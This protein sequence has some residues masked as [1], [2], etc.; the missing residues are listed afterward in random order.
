V[1]SE[2]VTRYELFLPKSA[3]P[4]VTFTLNQVLGFSF[5]VN[6][7]DGAGRVGWMEWTT[8]IGMTKTP[9]Y[10][11][12]IALVEEIPEPDGG[13]G[14]QGGTGAA[15]GGSGTG[16]AGAS[17]GTPAAAAD[18]SDGCGCR[19]HRGAAMGAAWLWLA[20]LWL[21]MRRRCR[22]QSRP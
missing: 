5:L 3:L 7:A 9:Y 8:G 19:T 10:F 12:E 13:V 2:P 21:A 1:R 6:D 17:N 18:S 22:T 15:P 11:G 14:G 16:G 20:M 4:S